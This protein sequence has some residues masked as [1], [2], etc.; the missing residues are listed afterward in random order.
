MPVELYT[1]TLFGC[2]DGESVCEFSSDGNKYVRF[3]DTNNKDGVSTQRLDLSAGKYNYHIKCTDAGGNVVKGIAKFN[4]TIDT[5]APVVARI[6]KEGTMLKVVTVRDS[7][8]A[9]SL[10]N[11]D[12]GFKDGINMPYGNTTT[13]VT[14]WNEKNNLLYQM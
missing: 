2:N 12:F 4:V 7:Q 10:D 3:F 13:H 6:Y 8:C 9:Y 11:C 1:K 5:A 14:D